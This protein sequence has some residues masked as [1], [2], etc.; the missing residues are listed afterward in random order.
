MSFSPVQPNS[1]R[2]AGFT[3][4]VSGAAW[5][6]SAAG[7]MLSRFVAAERATPSPPVCPGC[8]WLRPPSLACI[9]RVQAGG[10]FRR[11]RLAVSL[12]SSTDRFPPPQ[13]IGATTRQNSATDLS[14]RPLF[15]P[16][17]F[18][19]LIRPSE[20]LCPAIRVA[21]HNVSWGRLTPRENCIAELALADH[22]RI[23]CVVPRSREL[24]VDATQSLNR[25]RCHE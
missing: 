7:R 21:S 18:A 22:I 3:A 1:H 2:N 11:R 15:V 23:C 5:L 10:A 8:R 19:A 20:D 4:N 12:F 24:A 17:L 9:N 16:M 13:A 25:R 6:R 14:G